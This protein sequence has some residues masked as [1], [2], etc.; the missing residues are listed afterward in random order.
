MVG[1]ET[2]WKEQ[3]APVE[4][5]KRKKRGRRVQDQSGREVAGRRETRHETATER[6]SPSQSIRMGLTGA[7]LLVLTRVSSYWYEDHERDGGRERKGGKEKERSDLAPLPLLR[8][9]ASSVPAVKVEDGMGNVSV[10]DTCFP[11]GASRPENSSGQRAPLSRCR[12]GKAR[13]EE[14]MRD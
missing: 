8:A 7:P 6:S 13:R 12:I 11:R 1:G 4:R 2:K 5:R 3:V 9:R 10:I 14:K